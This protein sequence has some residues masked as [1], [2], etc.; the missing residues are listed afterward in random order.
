M[1]DYPDFDL[2]IETSSMSDVRKT[3]ST[4][5]ADI[6]SESD[7]Y[8]EFS[9]ARPGQD[10]LEGF[11]TQNTEEG[12]S[13][14]ILSSYEFTGGENI[15]LGYVDLIWDAFAENTSYDMRLE[16]FGETISPQFTRYRIDGVVSEEPVAA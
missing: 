1:A 4:L 2:Y 8:M 12:S 10:D 13:Q 7:R 3:L 16:Q 5:K 9:I 15:F 14:I 11:V 6:V